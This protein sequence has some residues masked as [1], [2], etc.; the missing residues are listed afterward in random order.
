MAPSPPGPRQRPQEPQARRRPLV[1]NNLEDQVRYSYFIPAPGAYEPHNPHKPDYAEPRRL[2][3]ISDSQVPSALDHQPRAKSHVPGP[4]AYANDGGRFALPEGGRLNRNAPKKEAKPFDEYP[5]PAPGDYG[6]PGHPGKPSTLHGKFSKQVKNPKYI[7][8]EVVRS[9]GIPGPGA[10]DVQGSM[11]SMKPFCPEGGRYLSQSKPTSYFEQAP[12]LADGKPG[13]DRYNLQGG[14]E[15]RAVGRLVY[16]YESATMKETKALVQKAMGERSSAPGPG[17]YDLPEPPPIAGAPS[18]KSRNTKA[19]PH[20]FAYDCQPDHGSKF[21]AETFTPVRQH[22]SAGLIY[23]NGVRPEDVARNARRSSQPPPSTGGVEQVQNQELP[24]PLRGIDEEGEEVVHWK[25]GGF[26]SLKKV[27]SAP[28]VGKQDHPFVENARRHYPLLAAKNREG[29]A[30]FR[31]MASRKAETVSTHELSEEHQRLRGGK[32]KLAAV[33]EGIQ[34]GM[35]AALE[36]LD[37]DKLKQGAMEGLRDKAKARMRLEGVSREQQS[38]VLEELSSVLEDHKQ[39]S[40]LRKDP[41][42][43]QEAE[44]TTSP[45]LPTALPAETLASASAVGPAPV[46]A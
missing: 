12:T 1:A 23:G 44:V 20:P 40:R 6:A 41:V 22:N 31:P 29:A 33:A 2:G 28:S 15:D 19:M 46:M 9:R 3:K 24:S 39:A 37:L 11:E 10:H 25:A 5:S 13:P 45:V 36:P 4:G 14:V 30:S 26:T 32:W 17:A 42:S 38:L 34:N 43:G 35:A 16:R 7:M 18:L 21:L 27:R 8:D